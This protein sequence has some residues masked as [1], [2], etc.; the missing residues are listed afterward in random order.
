MAVYVWKTIPWKHF[1]CDGVVTMTDNLI[2]KKAAA[3]FFAS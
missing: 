1:K 2:L 3:I